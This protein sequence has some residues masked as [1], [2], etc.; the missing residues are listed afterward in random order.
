M[1]ATLTDLPSPGVS[2][3]KSIVSDQIT[4]RE[5]SRVL[6]IQTNIRSVMNKRDELESLAAIESPSVIALTETWLHA[7]VADS[8]VTLPG[9]TI[10]RC[11]R[12]VR[13]GGGVM[14]LVRDDH[15]SHLLYTSLDVEGCYEGVW[16]KVKLSPSGY[17]TVGV[18]YRTPGSQPYQLLA[19]IR[20]FSNGIHCLLLGDFN[21]PGI[22]WSSDSTSY[23]DPFSRDFL[24]TVA[25]LHLYQHVNVP[26]RVTSQSANI[27][28]LV[29]SSNDSDVH[30][31]QILPPMGRSDHAVVSFLWRHGAPTLYH[32]CRSKNVWKI[33]FENLREAARV[34]DWIPP[35]EDLNELWQHIS[36]QIRCLVNHFAPPWKARSHSK[37]PPWFDA[38]LRRLLR[39]RN[40]AWKTFKATGEGYDNY[41]QIRNLILMYFKKLLK[42]KQYEEQLALNSKSAP[43]RLFA[44]LRRRTRT[45]SRIP[46][47]SPEGHPETPTSKAEAFS[48]HY[49][50]VYI[51]DLSPTPLLQPRLVGLW[52][53]EEIS[54]EEVA[55]QLRLLNPNKSPGPDDLHPLVLKE[56]ADVLAG[57]LTRLFNLSLKYGALPTEWKTAVVKP[58]F[59]SGSRLEPGN[60]RPVSLTCVLC[61]VMEKIVT[62]R[63]KIYLETNQLLHAGQHGFRSKRSCITN[64][65]IA[66]ESWAEA[67]SCN[68]DVDVIYVD[69]SKAFDKVPHQRL[70]NKLEAYG[71]AGGTLRW[72]TD[73]LNGRTFQVRIERALS[74]PKAVRSGV[75]QGSVL[76]PL[77]FLIYINDLLDHIT[78]PCLLYADDVKIW[79]VLND[80]DD[81]DA[82]QEDLDRLI[83][84]S[85]TW[86]L[87]INRSKSTYIHIGNELR[88]NAY[89]M[90]G[91][92]LNVT[93]QEKDLGVLVSDSLKTAAHTEMIC[94][95]SR[96]MVG[97]IRRS[98]CKL[99]P[100]AFQVLYST[101]IRSRLEYGSVVTYPCTLG[102]L[103]DIERVQRAAT[104]LVDGMTGLEYGER[105]IALDL[106]PQSYRRV[107]GDLIAVRHVLKGDYGVE[108]Q[109]YF[110]L[111]DDCG[112]RGHRYTLQ[113]RRTN[114]PAKLC[115]SLRAV[116]LWN[117]L[118]ADVVDEENETSFKKKLD[119]HLREMWLREFI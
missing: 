96:R 42:R 22:D 30:H 89:H 53:D 92:L 3:P 87:P 59:K 94:S 116:N 75:P 2:E 71:I 61:K 117:S 36:A 49:A 38:E 105:L 84:W 88:T 5:G 23:L 109:K 31:L 82:L 81:P 64:L 15:E 10:Y 14:L 65:M 72:I 21:T 108:A 46:L 51:D 11:D 26:T 39:R 106:F 99:T 100:G 4:A 13:G 79:R 77:L 57:P 60:Y 16:C 70:I 1:A 6:I 18:V 40:R 52:N 48:N 9:Y 17:D 47:V 29:L 90:K 41:R 68:K 73:F 20:R 25:D 114:V 97:A 27:L 78:S 83:N 80:E 44:Y 62:N 74:G 119:Q 32:S 43:K 24:S 28:D 19:D 45:E 56:L 113:K 98:F 55:G 118:P 34:L 91:V 76:G 8:E 111:R 110:P 112:R 95:S 35:T 58:M 37:G 103:E 85:E 67:R 7:E 50:A 33:Q 54:T 115:L 69:F 63:I 86:Q 93:K 101:H 12:S 107:R 66:R 102:E 104:K